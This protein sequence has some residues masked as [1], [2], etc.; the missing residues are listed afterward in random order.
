MITCQQIVFWYNNIH[1][2]HGK[3]VLA[4]AEKF[5][6]LTVRMEEMKKREYQVALRMAGKTMNEHINEIAD[7]FIRKNKVVRVPEA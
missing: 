1:R 4:L 7:E 5:L 2:D 3:R 6:T